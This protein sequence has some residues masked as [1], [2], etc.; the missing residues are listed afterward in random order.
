[1]EL[2]A[3]R[4]SLVQLGVALAVLATVVYFQFLR[5]PGAPVRQRLPE[6][7]PPAPTEAAAGAPGL[8]Q[9]SAV[10]R[11]GGRFR[12]RLGRPKSDDAPD[13]MTA[14]ASLRTE[15]LDRI[16]GIEEPSVERDI[17]N[18]GR[19]RRPEVKPPTPAET[20]Q[21]QARLE[22]ALRKPQPAPAGPAPRKVPPAAKPPDW[23]YYGLASLP[24]QDTRRAFLLDG[25]EILVA[26]EGALIQERYRIDRIGLETLV[27]EDVQAQQEFTLPL[28]ASR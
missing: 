5:N 13:P 6:S 26:A 2:G 24:G 16:R 28:E 10:R 27:L 11:T 9:V 1:M 8:R 4:K 25:E 7:S 21:A 12:P 20:K 22:A 3:N 14:D 19:P 23:K 17:F 18:F 15:L